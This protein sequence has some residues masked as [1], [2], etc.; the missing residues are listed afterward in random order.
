MVS[1][2]LLAILRC[3]ATHQPLIP[4]DADALAFANARIA[5]GTVRTVDGE[6]VSAP[7]TEALVTADGQRVYPV[8]DG[9]PILLVEEALTR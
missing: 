2:E 6:T 8:R 1:P 4:A 7:L 3:P 9:I 5:A